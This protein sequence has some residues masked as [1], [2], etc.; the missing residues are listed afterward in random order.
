[1][2]SSLLHPSVFVL[3]AL[4][5][6]WY[7]WFIFIVFPYYSLYLGI[8][9]SL[10]LLFPRCLSY[11]HLLHSILFPVLLSRG[12]TLLS[13]VCYPSSLGF[14]IHSLVCCISILL[15]L[16]LNSIGMP[17]I[18]VPLRILFLSIFQFSSASVSTGNVSI[19]FGFILWLVRVGLLFLLIGF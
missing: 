6:S 5:L 13:Y 4:S 7:T 3:S 16:F 1:M 14:L 12:L 11:Y 9:L 18:L 15:P 2:V 8:R 17:L 19:V 10:V